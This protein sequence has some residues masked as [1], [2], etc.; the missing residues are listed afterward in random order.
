[1]A[2]GQRLFAQQ[3]YPGNTGAERWLAGVQTEMTRGEWVDPLLG[4]ELLAD[5]ANRWVSL[6]YISPRIEAL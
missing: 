2:S 5:F 6:R 1:M 4:E 3:R